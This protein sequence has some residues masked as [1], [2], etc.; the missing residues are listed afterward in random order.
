MSHPILAVEHLT[1]RF[2]VS[3]PWLVR[4]LTGAPRRVLTAVND[5]SFAIAQGCTL[6]IVGESGCGKSTVAR[7]V[8]GLMTPSGGSVRFRGVAVRDIRGGS[9]S[10]RHAIQMIFQDPYGS[11][12]PRWRVGR[13]VGD[14]LRAFGLVSGRA[15][16]KERVGRLLADVGL[17]AAD[18]DKFPHEFSGGQ[19]QRIAVARALAAGPALVVCDEPT[20]ALDVSVQAQI[21]NLMRELQEA[22]GLT[23][24]FISH[25]LAVVDFMSDT[26][27][28][29]YLGSIV[30]TAPRD[31]LFARPAHPYPRMLLAASPTPDRIGET[32]ATPR[33]EVPNPIDPPS[34]CAFH[35]RCPH[36]VERCRIERPALREFGAARVACHRADDIA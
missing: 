22:R 20:S 33:G 35:P 11:L 7:C 19:R 25:N 5:V 17:S 2:D 32:A 30:E 27:A 12:N 15:E 36:T 6:S 9:A 14:P 16:L 8:A 24:L 4:T 13:I 3:E 26:V 34:G 18:A 21:L 31:D 29:M 1:K 23:F 10:E 28:V